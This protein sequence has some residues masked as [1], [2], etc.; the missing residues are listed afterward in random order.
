[1]QEYCT[2]EELKDDA[3]ESD[4]IQFGTSDEKFMLSDKLFEIT[5][6]AEALEEEKMEEN[7]FDETLE[8]ARNY[9][10][11][12]SI[13][14][15]KMKSFLNELVIKKSSQLPKVSE[16]L[17]NV[18][19]THKSMGSKTLLHIASERG[20]NEMVKILLKLTK[21][22]VTLKDDVGNTALHYSAK[23]DF[24]EIVSASRFSWDIYCC[25]VEV[26]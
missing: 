21:K 18:D 19:I 23:Y 16:L 1:M 20:D 4:R 17:N 10:N 13:D 11:H 12:G 8:M 24:K 26:R 5:N 7:V 6:T 25:F 9:R 3:T 22:L 2:K 14:L 15:D